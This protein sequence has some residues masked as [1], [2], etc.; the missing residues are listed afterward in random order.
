M[1]SQ[2]FLK[3]TSGCKKYLF[4]CQTNPNLVASPPLNILTQHSKKT[5]SSIIKYLQTAS[6]YISPDSFRHSKQFI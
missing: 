6:N 3:V 4:Y 5:A 1:E 2:K